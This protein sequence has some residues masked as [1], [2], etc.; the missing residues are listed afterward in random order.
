MGLLQCA[1]DNLNI[2][3]SSCKK[4]P[5]QPKAIIT[6]PAG[7]SLTAAEIQDPTAWQNAMIAAKGVR[8]YLF[9]PVVVFENISEAAVYEEGSLADIAVRDGRYKFRLS[10]QENLNLHKNIF[11]HKNFTGRVWILDDKNQ[12]TAM[13][14]DGELTFKGFTIGLFNPEK[15]T[16]NDG[17][18][19]SKTPIY[20]SLADNLELD[21][22]GVIFDAA[23]IN[24]LIRLTTVDLLV[25]AVPAPSAT[26]FTVSVLSE[27]DNTPILGLVLAD[28]VLLD[29]A[30]AAQTITVLND[31]GDGTYD[32]TGVG[33]VTGT[34]NLVAAD[35]LTIVAFESS[36]AVIVT[37]V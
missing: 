30:G 14:D 28:F 4:L 5:Q 34:I 13:S 33:L 19:A 10:V 36:G 26:G 3:V 11:S 21:E 27:L 6:T 17:S 2:G 22:T 37:I 9:P 32:V 16:F 29:A 1:D 8:I 35:A 12:L 15:L 20:L 25:L 24:S 7:F 23:F 18:L 31:N